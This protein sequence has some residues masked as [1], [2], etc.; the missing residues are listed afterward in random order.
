MGADRDDEI[1]RR[2]ER[3][4]LDQQHRQ[5][6]LLY[7]NKNDAIEALFR[8]YGQILRDLRTGRIRAPSDDVKLQT[9][10]E[11]LRGL[12]HCLRW[13]REC[14]PSRIV[15]P[16]AAPNVLAREAH[17]L[18]GWGV[19]YDSI[20][21]HYSAYSRGQVKA[22]VDERKKVITFLPQRD[23]NPR[24]FVTQI[25]A[26]KADDERC[27]A[28][29]PD[30][31]LAKLAE[32]WC[33]SARFSG[34]R[35]RF[36]DATI[37][38]SGAI[39]LAVSWMENTCLPEV[40]AATSLKGCTVEELRR[41][42]ATLYVHSVFVTKLEDASD[43]EPVCGFVLDP[44]VVA[45]QRNEM[46]HWLAILSGVRED[47]VEAILAVLT[48]DP[49]HPHVTLAQ[50]PFVSSPDGQLFYLPRM[51]LLLDLPRIYIGA[52]NKDM[53]GRAAYAKLIN[54]VEAAEVKSIAREI[55]A[56]VSNTLQMA[57]KSSFRLPDG[58]K[59]TPDLVLFSEADQ[60]VLVVDVKH[61]TPPF[62]PA[63]VSHDM[64]E[65]EKWKKRVLEYVSSFRSNPSV[66]ARR[67]QWRFQR[68]PAVF[69]LILLRWPLPIPVDFPDPTCAP[70][71]ICAVDWP[72]LREYLQQGCFTSIRDVMAW[73]YNRPDVPDPKGLTPTTKELQ[74]GEWTFRYVV[75]T[76]LPK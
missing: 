31:Q 18:L 9:A 75:L 3:E 12:A 69:G 71:P 22:E 10:N 49:T 59:I 26:K 39:D 5:C 62:G 19:R 1:V 14:G 8:C 61:A 58:R 36:D 38:A 44:H 65:M 27:A 15:V 17:E 32:T 67:F 46:I 50:Q 53:Q 74:V 70:D 34:Q 52:L 25:E 35:L 66:L 33:E 48:F 42:L 4:L 68:R 43:D 56:A 21:N 57:T 6:A 45:R 55:R 37:R 73:A 20:W 11:G 29:R 64:E 47:S 76:A 28:A 30:A 40:N 63:D 54:E 7:R 51:L 60:T 41:V 2:I 72:S 24:F 13:I 23:V 16:R